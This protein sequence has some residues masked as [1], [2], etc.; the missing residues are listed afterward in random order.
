MN[1]ILSGLGYVSRAITRQTTYQVEGLWRCESCFDGKRT[2]AILEA[3]NADT[4]YCGSSCAL[5]S[6]PS[7]YFNVGA[8]SPTSESIS[9]SRVGR[10]TATPAPSS[11]G[12]DHLARGFYT[13]AT[14]VVSIPS[15]RTAQ[16]PP[17]SADSHQW[18]Y[19]TNQHS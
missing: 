10:G 14:S 16:S 12:V 7:R 5:H 1:C 19:L 9:D 6:C 3:R 18:F 4:T 8:K 13:W 17:F 15:S 11:P 2:Y